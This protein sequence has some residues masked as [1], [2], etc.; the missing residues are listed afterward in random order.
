VRF[1]REGMRSIM[2]AKAERKIVMMEICDDPS[3]DRTASRRAKNDNRHP[4]Q[5]DVLSQLEAMGFLRRSGS[6]FPRPPKIRGGSSQGRAPKADGLSG[7]RSRDA[8]A[9]P[10]PRAWHSA[11]IARVRVSIL[12]STTD[13]AR[14]RPGHSSR[15]ITTLNQT[16][17]LKIQARPSRPSRRPRMSRRGSAM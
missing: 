6:P 11:D 14:R 7:R 5:V 8:G 16:H 1:F 17:H 12:F 4:Q 10:L 9:T 3:C 2:D 15:K 13:R